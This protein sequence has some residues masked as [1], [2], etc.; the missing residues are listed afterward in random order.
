MQHEM[1][2]LAPQ[3]LDALYANPKP[4]MHLMLGGKVR[5]H[6]FIHLQGQLSGNTEACNQTWPRKAQLALPLVSEQNIHGQLAPAGFKVLKSL[7]K[8]Y[9]N[10]LMDTF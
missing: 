8:G 5:S 10:K 6:C 7:L 9:T 4:K 3:H 2:D 1:H